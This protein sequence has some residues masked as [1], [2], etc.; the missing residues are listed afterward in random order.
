MRTPFLG[1]FMVSVGNI[2][3][4]K[5]LPNTI[6]RKL[7]KEE[8]DA[9]AEP[10]STISSRKPLRVWPTEIPFDGTPKNIHQIVSSYHNWLKQ[11]QLPKLLLY[12]EPGLLIRKKDVLW[13]QDNFPNTKV[14]SVGKGLHFIQEDSPDA[15]GT[16]L[17]KWYQTI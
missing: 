6:I 16:E 12:A 7:S 8:S 2:F 15:I 17:A 11:T 3:I 13:I 4:K 1:W 14:I 10:Y 9:Y 5:L